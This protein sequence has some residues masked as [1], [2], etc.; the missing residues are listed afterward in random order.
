MLSA[1]ASMEKT[2]SRQADKFNVRLPEGMRE[3][4]AREAEH[5]HRSMNAE[6]VGR[7]LKSLELPTG[8]ADTAGHYGPKLTDQ[9]ADMLNRFRAMPARKQQALLELLG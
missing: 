5:N 3:R 4:I 2:P 9:E 7:L 1:M 8:V 6:I